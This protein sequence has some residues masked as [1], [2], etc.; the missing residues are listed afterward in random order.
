MLQIS[1]KLDLLI[2][3]GQNLLGSCGCKTHFTVDSEVIWY[4]DFEAAYAIMQKNCLLGKHLL[5]DS[6]LTYYKTKYNKAA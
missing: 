1:I 2:F 4:T 6:D 5:P 3:L